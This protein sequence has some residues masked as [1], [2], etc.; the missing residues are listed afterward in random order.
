MTERFNKG[1]IVFRGIPVSTGVC[2]GKILVLDK[3]QHTITR[4]EIAEGEI[5]GEVDRL[6][7][8]LVATR[9]QISEVQHK[10]SESLGAE[11]ASIFDAHLLVLEDPSLIDEVM[12][13]VQVQRLNVEFAFQSVAER[14]AAALATMNDEYLRERAS[15]M[16]DVTS[17]V[18]NNLLGHVDEIDLRHL[19]EP[20]II[21]AHDLTP[22]KT[23]QMDRKNVLGFATDIGS[24][25]SHTA[26][27]AR[28]LRIPAAVGLKNAS[29][30][31]ESGQ[32]AMLDGFNGTLV[33]NP[34]EQTLFEYGQLIKKQ[35][36][37]EEKLR[38]ALHKP[39]ITLD[40]HRVFLSANI[41][42]PDDTGAA[43]ECGSE[44]V[45]LFRTEYLFIN[46]EEIGRASCRERVSVL[47]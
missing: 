39:A 42:S 16:R 13:S 20:V 26:I 23:A 8:A 45:G 25:T 18:L 35:V 30:E 27:M 21:I 17:R 11:H 34:T 6:Q 14:Y 4:R 36:S 1:E 32:Y 41:E 5:L 24:K 43:K 28:S 3:T 15:D 10:I 33:V 22:S 7:K 29:A 31:L 46:R 44:G 40:N 37:L 38:D 2:R 12:R 47:V 9:H 19:N